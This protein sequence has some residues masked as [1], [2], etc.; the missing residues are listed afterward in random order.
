MTDKGLWIPPAI[1]CKG[2]LS[3]AEKA[4][5]ATVH[6]F[7]ANDREFYQTN[8]T[9]AKDLAVSEST[10]KRAIQNLTTTGCITSVA[11]DGRKRRIE[12][13]LQVQNELAGGSKRTTSKVKKTQQTGQNEPAGRSKRPTK[14]NTTTNSK[15][16]PKKGGKVELL[17]PFE[18]FENIWQEWRDY[19]WEQH[20]FKYK[21]QKS[22]Q[23]AL[24]YLQKLSRHDKQTAIEIIGFSIANGYKG[25]FEPRGNSNKATQP[26]ADQFT[27]Y[28]RNGN[29]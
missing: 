23:A 6:S 8:A 7:A 29:L 9:I 24:H 10:V 15:N 4:I 19:K 20:R 12:L 26:S 18:D 21:S 22:E 5:L 28:I 11:F 17:M 3:L 16:K 27:E 14:N 25:L 2:E 1:W 13:T